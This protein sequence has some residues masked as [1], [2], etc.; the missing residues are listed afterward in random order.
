MLFAGYCGILIAFGQYTLLNARKFEQTMMPVGCMLFFLAAL[1]CFLIQQ[2]PLRF[3]WLTWAFGFFTGCYTPG[4]AGWVLGLA[5]LIYLIA[6]GRERILVLTVIYGTECL[7]I[8]YLA[9]QRMRPGLLSSEFRVGT[10]GHLTFGDWVL[11]CMSGVRAAVGSDFTLVPAPLALAIGA[12]VYLG[13]R[14]RDYRYAAVCA[15]AAA[16]AVLGI[17]L[18]GTEFAFPNRDIQRAM[19]VIPP[20][21][22]G[23]VVLLTRF[24]CDSKE[25][26]G[27]AGTAKLLMKLSMGYMVFTGVFTVLLVRSFFGT[28]MLDD[29]DEAFVLVDRL[30]H[31]HEVQP[32]LIYM[33]PPM[34]INLA[35]GLQYFA[36]DAK[37]VHGNPP[38]GEKVAGAYVLSYLK[39]Y[40]FDDELVPSRN[41]RPFI[42]MERE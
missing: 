38:A 8:T 4:L 32:K 1:L 19:I 39:T 31:S 29:E 35:P 20:L 41:P 23:T 17:V 16:T 6:R 34:D 3:L 30:V 18:L 14:L 26:Q 13:W 7:C 24:L 22:L 10:D 25:A 33:T 36:P 15:W 11:R 9:M 2:G 12:G 28:T 37:V 21:A 40:R 27:A 42:R 5:V